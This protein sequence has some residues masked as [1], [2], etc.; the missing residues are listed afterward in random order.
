[1]FLLCS[2]YTDKI[3]ILLF[4]EGAESEG[5]LIMFLLCSEYTDKNCIVVILRLSGRCV[6]ITSVPVCP[7]F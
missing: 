5:V 3:C 2:D 4:L 6:T 7:S 1:M